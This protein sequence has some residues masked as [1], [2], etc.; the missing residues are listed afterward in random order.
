MLFKPTG[1]GRAV[2]SDEIPRLARPVRYLQAGS[3]FLAKRRDEAECAPHSPPAKQTSA[4][5]PRS[6]LPRRQG[7]DLVFLG[8]LDFFFCSRPR[9]LPSSRRTSGGLRLKASVLVS[10]DKLVKMLEN[11]CTFPLESDL[12]AQV[13]HPSK[14]LLTVGL[15]SG[16]VETFRLPS[17]DEGSLEDDDDENSS[18]NGGKGLIKSAWSTRRHKGSC[19]CLAYSYDGEGILALPSPRYWLLV[20][21][22]Y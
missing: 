12:F 3:N 5:T 19:R 17:S 9:K 4:R 8:A 20:P 13:L 22:L 1:C 21:R 11:L 18:I 16:R 10:A 6:S 2:P 14:P 7:Y 15:S